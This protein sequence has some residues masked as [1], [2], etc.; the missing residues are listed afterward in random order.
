MCVSLFFALLSHCT[1]RV[2]RRVHFIQLLSP[3]DFLSLIMCEYVSKKARGLTLFVSIHFTASRSC[4][5]VCSFQ[6]SCVRTALENSSTSYSFSALLPLFCR[7]F[8]FNFQLL[9]SLPSSRCLILHHRRLV[10]FVTCCCTSLFIYFTLR[11]SPTH[12]EMLILAD[13]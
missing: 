11:S 13:C 3:K 2:F 1:R 7:Q 12:R 5:C 8:F 6:F 10:L 9:F 4:G